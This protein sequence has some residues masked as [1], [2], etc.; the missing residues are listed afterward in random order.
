M[1]ET[2]SE[3]RGPKPIAAY[4][5]LRGWQKRAYERD[6]AAAAAGALV[7]QIEA[8]L[9]GI[10]NAL[11]APPTNDVLGQIAGVIPAS[12]VW[13]S[14]WPLA[15]SSVA[16]A[17][18]G[19]QFVTVTQANTIAAPSQGVGTARVGGGRFRVLALRGTELSVWGPPGTPFDVTA[20]AR[21]REPAGGECGM[22]AVPVWASRQVPASTAA[23]LSISPPSASQTL[24]LGGISQPDGGAAGSE[25]YITGL[26]EGGDLFLPLGGFL[27]P[28]GDFNPPLPGVQGEP[29]TWNC[30]AT[31]NTNAFAVTIWGFA[32]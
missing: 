24:Y 25:T 2:Y 20:Y 31:F 5:P 13:S 6:R 32:V 7:A 15:F 22:A 8:H 1:S 16:V 9:G 19:G 10:Y 29:I 3:A 17:N 26:A 14:S 23:T 28:T 18:L 21:P 12:G 30:S 11:V 27:G 4:E